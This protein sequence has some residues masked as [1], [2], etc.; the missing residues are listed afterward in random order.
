MKPVSRQM[1]YPKATEI[2]VV[3]LE[4]IAQP[5]LLQGLAYW[6]SLRG[7]RAFPA[8][9]DIR[10]R[11]LSSVLK[12]MVFVKVLDGADDFLLKVVGDEVARCYCAPL[13]NRR[14]SEIA[15]DLPYSVTRWSALYRKVALSGEP[16]A[17]CVRVGGEKPEL[18]FTHSAT[19]CLP[20]GATD[21]GVD[22]LVTFGQHFSRMDD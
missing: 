9:E 1:E 22:H 12:H 17:V 5:V 4:A 20:F 15:I 19:I 11:E 10:L 8:R 3:A 16:L 21:D 13:I 2:E 18:N 14:M 7:T 6:Q